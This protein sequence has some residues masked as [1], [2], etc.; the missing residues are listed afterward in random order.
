MLFCF[1]CLRKKKKRIRT[2]EVEQYEHVTEPS[3]RLAPLHLLGDTTD[4]RS[5]SQPNTDT[6]GSKEHWPK[7]KKKTAFLPVGQLTDERKRLLNFTTWF[8]TERANGWSGW[9]GEPSARENW[10]SQY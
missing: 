2:L 8:L 6:L 7:K 9:G 3:K 5:V 4:P 10:H 1:I